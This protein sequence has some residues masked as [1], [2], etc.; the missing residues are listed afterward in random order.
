MKNKTLVLI[1]MVCLSC[2]TATIK[3]NATIAFENNEF[4][5]GELKMNSNADCKF[6]FQNPGETP[7]L[8]QNVETTCGCAEPEWSSKPIKPGKIGEIKITYDTSH[9]GIFN[10]TI[11]VFYNGKDS[12]QKLVIKGRIDYSIIEPAETVEPQK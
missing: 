7:L 3:N 11:T 12:P 5:F 9:P 4:D 10:K 2:S 8:I 1:C 6:V